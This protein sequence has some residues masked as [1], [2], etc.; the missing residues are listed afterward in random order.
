MPA[1][2]TWRL[3]LL[4]G[5]IGPAWACPAGRVPP[6]GGQGGCSPS[7]QPPGE[8]AP[9]TEP[10]S[11]ALDFPGLAE[12]PQAAPGPSATAGSHPAGAKTGFVYSDA[13][14]AHETGEGHPERPERLTAIVRRLER[15]GLLGQLERIEPR[16]ATRPWLTTLHAPAYIDRVERTC[17]EGPA[18]LDSPD[19][20]VSR[21]SFQAALLA[22]GGVMAAVDAVLQGKVRN[23][24]C[25]IRPPGHHALRDR[26]MGFCLFGNVALAARYAQRRYNLSRVLI[27]DW[28]VHH[29]N[30]TQAFFEEDPSV[31]YFSVHRSP[32]Y[33]GT[34]HA[35][36]R[37]SGAAAGTKLNVPLP[38]GS[39]GGAYERAFAEQLRPAALAFRPDCVFISAGFDAHADDPLGGMRL[40]A[41]DYGRL[42]AAVKDIAAQA[43]RGRLVSVLEGGYSLE[44]IAA[45]VEAHLRELM[46]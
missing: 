6:I 14:L 28:D 9:R 46:K 38:A 39:A 4:A 35:E 5:V 17:R 33:P 43:C 37:G 11:R 25:A 32:F 7:A 24:F 30:G 27:V 18:Y 3:L 16:A 45:S 42:T 13:F 36:D 8:C 21:G 29:G 31:F 23:A 22:A 34:G 2:P 12:S 19:T 20:P 15:A 1:K 40:T 41:E 10:S 44:G 26:A